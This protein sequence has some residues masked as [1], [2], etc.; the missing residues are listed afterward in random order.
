MHISNMALVMWNAKR[1]L[2]C[3]HGNCY[4]QSVVNASIHKELTVVVGSLGIGVGKVPGVTDGSDPFFEYGNPTFAT[5]DDFMGSCYTTDELLDAHVWAEDDAGRIYDIVTPHMHNVALARNL[6][7]VYDPMQYLN[8]VTRRD[9]SKR[10]LCY[11]RAS[12]EAQSMLLDVLHS[13]SHKKI[14][15][16]SRVVSAKPAGDDVWVAL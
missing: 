14:H 10:G 1:K 7:L 9:A 13:R 2:V 5:Y 6:K 3:I 4:T 11:V 16:L 8:G 15:M 12:P